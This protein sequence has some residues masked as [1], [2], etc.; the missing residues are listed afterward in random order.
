MDEDRSQRLVQVAELLE[1]AIRKLLPATAGE[2][3]APTWIAA[4]ARMAGCFLLRASLPT[5]RP[6]PPAGTPLLTAQA[7]ARGPRLVTLMLSTARGLG[8]A[9]GDNEVRD[10]GQA[11]TCP[12]P[13]LGL[14]DTLTRLDPMLVAIVRATGIGFDEAAAAAS[15]AAARLAVEHRDT[16]PLAQGLAIAVQGLVEGSKTSPPPLPDASA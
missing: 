1:M 16:L 10:A 6:P 14:L 15:I 11:P 2:P 9:V 12:R 8:G 4:A 13:S 7:N 5:D 3:V